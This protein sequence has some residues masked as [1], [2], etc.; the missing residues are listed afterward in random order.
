MTDDDDDDD[1][2]WEAESFLNFSTAG[3][4]NNITVA[5]EQP[6]CERPTGHA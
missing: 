5:T 2:H 4:Q 6:N 3:Y 1:F